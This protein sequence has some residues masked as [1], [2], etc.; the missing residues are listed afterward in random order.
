MA[1]RKTRNRDK[2]HLENIKNKKWQCQACGRCFDT[3]AVLKLH[4]KEK[5]PEQTS[6]GW[7]IKGKTKENCESLRRRGETYKKRYAEGKIKSWMKGRHHSEETKKKL[8]EARKAWILAHPEKSPYVVSHYTRGESYSEKY[9]REWMEKEN[10]PFLAQQHLGTY[11]LD[12]LVG[13]IDL[14]IDGEQH[15]NDPRIT[16]SDERRNKYVQEQGLKVIR[17]RWKHYTNLNQQ[18]RHDYLERLKVALTTD[19][20]LNDNF[21]IDKRKL[22]KVYGKCKY[23]SGNIT[24][25]TNKAYCSVKCANLG[26]TKSKINVDKYLTEDFYKKILEDFKT[27]KVCAL[28]RKYGVSHT[29]VR[30]W[31]NRAKELGYC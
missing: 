8:S 26:V 25:S 6:G 7:H 24:C 22:K 14:E 29:T 20:K 12:F 31:L 17:I 3:R 4:R 16:A 1:E 18:E 23:C 9:F 2:S 10:I 15:W 21:V 27:I 30:R 19:N 28:G 5:H 11:T 13:N